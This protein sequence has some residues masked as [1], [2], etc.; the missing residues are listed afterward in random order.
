MF[1]K[2]PAGGGGRGLCGF[3]TCGGG[4]GVGGGLL[5]RREVSESAGDLGGA[6]RAAEGWWHDLWA[7]CGAAARR[8]RL[9]VE[10]PIGSLKRRGM[11]R[12]PVFGLPARWARWQALAHNL[13]LL[14]VRG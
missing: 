10:R 9:R 7:D 3:A 2:R 14:G 8:V 5:F 1:A 6:V 12:I 11:R 13:L 4:A